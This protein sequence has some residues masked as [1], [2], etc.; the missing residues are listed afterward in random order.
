MKN[1]LTIIILAVF[2][3]HNSISQESESIVKQGDILIISKDS[4]VPFKHIHFPRKNFILKRGN[5]AN[6]KNLDGMAVR[7]EE[8][9]NNSDTK[10]RATL[11]PLSRKKFFNS[12]TTVTADISKA[13][14]SGE[15]VP[16]VPKG[17]SIAQ[18]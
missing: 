3:S 15:L 11:S 7:V 1:F 9:I 4:N 8:L 2:V 5:I 10:Q 6:Y 14:Q 16:H 13:I 12:Y 17:Q 18:Q